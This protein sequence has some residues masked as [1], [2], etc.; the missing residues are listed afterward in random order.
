M[1]TWI[2]KITAYWSADNPH[3]KHEVAFR[4]VKADFSTARSWEGLC[5]LFNADTV[6]VGRRHN[7]RTSKPHSS[8]IIATTGRVEKAVT[9]VVSALG[10]NALHWDNCHRILLCVYYTL[11]MPGTCL[12][13]GEGQS[14]DR[15]AVWRIF[16]YTGKSHCFM[17]W[18]ILQKVGNS[19]HTDTANLPRRI[20]CLQI[21]EC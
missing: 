14:H 10:R 12:P 2:H 21:I 18:K 16:T 11:V 9:Q 15:S 1:E 19:L 6:S 4:D 13:S 3:P 5:N 8:G 20:Q 17:A 7:K